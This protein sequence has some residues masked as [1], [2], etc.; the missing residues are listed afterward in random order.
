MAREA[1]GS[2]SKRTAAERRAQKVVDQLLNVGES[3]ALGSRNKPERL[4]WFRGLGLG[5]FITW[6][7]DSQLGSVISHSLVGA[8]ADYVRRFFHELPGTFNPRKF[9]PDAWA[10]L[11][12]VVGM[13]YVVFT[14][15]HHSGFCMFDT[16]TTDF[17][18][19]H[20]PARRDLMA[21]IVAA[22]RRQGLHI[23]LY[24]SPDDFHFL[25]RQ[26]RT[27]SRFRPD[28]MPCNNPALMAHN[29]KQVRELLSRYG[30]IDIIFFDGDPSGLR[31]LSWDVNPDIV[32]TRGAM[33]TPEQSLLD[34]ALTE[35][36]EACFTLG[37]QW[38]Y[39]P[40][41]EEHKSG[42]QLINML[43]ETRAKGGNLL[44][45]AGPSPDGE[46]PFEQE[47]R[48]REMGLWNFVN[49]E[50]VH[51]V[52]PWHTVNEGDVWFTKARKRA[53][54][55]AIVTGSPWRYREA[56]HVTLTSV[57]ATAK[58]DVELLGQSGEVLE[59]RTEVRPK[60]RWHQNKD[61]LT[62]EVTRAQRL[63]NNMSWPNPPVIRITHARA[64][65][66]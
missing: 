3:P 34:R 27:I 7:L 41:N 13:K 14:A 58:T 38:Q 8:S 10:T 19:M 24:F 48:F 6:S 52:V 15:K 1:S 66:C 18:V 31:E 2:P 65:R 62:I 53:T 23:G 11:A 51:D 9:D 60:G 22:F 28:A 37:N 16:G 25:H 5:M 57:R 42:G 46:I 32:V 36:W 50:A 40:T 54:V 44:I 4:A 39:K 26:G 17:S 21:E 30:P 56:R 55:Y 61:W 59:Y 43:I 49:A 33:A 35:P 20:T 29:K 64:A 63:Y 45:N 12:K 47:R